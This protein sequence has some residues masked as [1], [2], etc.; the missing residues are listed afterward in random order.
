[1]ADAVRQ[2]LDVLLEKLNRED[3]GYRDFMFLPVGAHFL[4]QS[5]SKLNAPVER[6]VHGLEVRPMFGY[7]R[8]QLASLSL[9]E[10]G[11]NERFSF[12]LGTKRLRVFLLAFDK[13]SLERSVGWRPPE[14]ASWKIHAIPV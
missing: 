6:I 11:A 3:T 2:L 9:I 10:I 5:G 12:L 4:L 13:F 7:R 8:D 1:V 14:W